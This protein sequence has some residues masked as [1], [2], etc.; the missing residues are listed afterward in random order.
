MKVPASRTTGS[1][2]GL[3]PLLS[4]TTRPSSF[5]SQAETT[6]SC[7]LL[8][9]AWVVAEVF[10]LYRTRRWYELSG[11]GRYHLLRTCQLLFPLI[12]PPFSSLMFC[13]H[14]EPGLVVPKVGSFPALGT[15]PF[16]F[17]VG[18]DA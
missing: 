15:C 1:L 3:A 10:A 18:P 8:G 11:L 17:S 16:F 2:F 9:D 4:G 7:A 6:T 5:W 13:C 12:T 14:L